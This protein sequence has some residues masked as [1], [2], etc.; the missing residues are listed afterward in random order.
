MP[1][2]IV[3]SAKILPVYWNVAETRWELL[4][5][6]SRKSGRI[7]PIGGKYN[8]F[9]HQGIGAVREYVEETGRIPIGG[10]VHLLDAIEITKET[11]DLEVGTQ[12][13]VSWYLYATNQAAVFELTPL[14]DIMAFKSY[15]L[16][17]AEFELSH[18]STRMVYGELLLLKLRKW[19]QD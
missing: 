10:L 7:K 11:S 5:G 14:D 15:G 18:E 6:V 8:P 2:E 19:Y 16:D 13:L 3:R 4:L 17:E 9:E 1:G 12:L